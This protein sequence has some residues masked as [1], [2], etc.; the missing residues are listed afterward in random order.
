M[1]LGINNILFLR[2]SLARLNA[3]VSSATP[4]P[5]APK[6]LTDTMPYRLSLG[7][8]FVSAS[9]LVIKPPPLGKAICSALLAA[10]SAR[11]AASVALIALLA[12]E[13]CLLSMSVFNVRAWLTNSLISRLSTVVCPAYAFASATSFSAFTTLA[14]DV[15]SAVLL[16]ASLSSTVRLNSVISPPSVF[17]VSAL[18]LIASLSALIFVYASIASFAAFVDVSTILR[19]TV[20]ASSSLPTRINKARFIFSCISCKINVTLS[21]MCS[22]FWKGY[23]SGKSVSCLIGVLRSRIILCVLSNGSPSA[24]YV[25]VLFSLS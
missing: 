1:P 11:F 24:G 10:T 13:V 3:A 12:T 8:N 2:L 6:S 18:A 19:A 5:T 17:M 23:S 21:V 9:V 20:V 16:V 7:I 22:I 25:K 14:L 4:S 15:L